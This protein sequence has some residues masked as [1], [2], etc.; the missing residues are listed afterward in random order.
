MV[1]LVVHDSDVDSVVSDIAQVFD[2]VLERR[3][4]PRFARF[5]EDFLRF[6]V[7]VGKSEMPFADIHNDTGGVIVQGRTFMRSIMD[8]YNLH[9]FIFKGKF[10][11]LRLNLGGVLCNTGIRCYQAYQHQRAQ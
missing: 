5:G 1:I 3:E 4:P 2:C 10:I 8:I 11:M 6:S 7:L 9:M